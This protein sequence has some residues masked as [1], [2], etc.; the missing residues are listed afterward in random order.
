MTKFELFTYQG[1]YEDFPEHSD[2]Y[3]A[4][5]AVDHHGA[6]VRDNTINELIAIGKALEHETEEEIA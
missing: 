6:G 3:Y 2:R 4:Q 1:S 5:L